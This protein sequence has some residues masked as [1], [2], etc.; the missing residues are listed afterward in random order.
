MSE[1]SSIKTLDV[2]ANPAP[3]GL[4]GF[5]MTTI[6][7]NL[8]N[9]GLFELDSTIMTMGVFYGGLAQF[10]VG[11]MEWKK[12]NTFGTV[13]F[14]SYGMFWLTLVGIWTL[15]ALG[16]V[17]QPT[18]V[19]MACYL[20]IWG[21]FSLFL[22]IGT[23][24]LSRALQVVF[25]TLVLLFFMLAWSKASGS[26]GLHTLAGYVGIVCGASA[27]YTAIAQVL[28]ELYKKKLLPL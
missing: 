19:S 21:L 27:F 6:L 23:F 5:G 26:H 20:G 17:A 12:N 15:P 25:G 10:I 2:T 18:A 22:F 16:A 28:N 9:A 1:V 24:K 3:L 13:A 7:L 11:M 8:H 14:C 4:C